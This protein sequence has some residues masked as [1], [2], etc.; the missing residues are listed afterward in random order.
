MIFRDF[1]FGQNVIGLPANQENFVELKWAAPVTNASKAV[2]WFTNANWGFGIGLPE[3]VNIRWRNDV[4]TW[5]PA[6]SVPTVAAKDDQVCAASPCAALS[7][8]KSARVTGVRGT[9]PK[10][11]AWTMVNEISL[12]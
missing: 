10:Y 7:L 1:I 11:G 12:M 3:K 6:T 5:Q 8:P 2:I 4:G 9:V